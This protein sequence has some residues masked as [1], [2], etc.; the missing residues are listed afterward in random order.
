MIL[1][2]L[3]LGRPGVTPL[4]VVS[5]TWHVNGDTLPFIFPNSVYLTPSTLPFRRCTRPR[6]TMDSLVAHRLRL[7]GP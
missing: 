5:L 2:T 3:L 1:K 6:R 7:K 4:V